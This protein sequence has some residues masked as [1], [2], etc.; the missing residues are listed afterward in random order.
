MRGVTLHNKWIGWI[1]FS[2]FLFHSPICPAQ[3]WKTHFAYNNVTQI[4]MSPD[5]VY[6][7]SDGSLYS[8][9]KQTEQ[10]QVYNSQS[11]LHSTGISCI[12]YDATGK[13]LI[14]A[15]FTGKIDILSSYGVKYISELYDKDMTQCK[16][17]YNVTIK[18]RTAYL[19]THYGVQTMDLRENK[20]VDSYW[21]RPGGQETPVKDVL[22][23]NDSIYAFT[24]DSLFCASMKSN[25]VDYTVWKRE[26]RSGRVAPDAEKGVHYQDATDHWYAGY[27][28]GIVRFTPTGRETYKPQGPINNTPYYVSAVGQQVF[29]L[30]GGRWTEQDNRPGNIMR[31]R[32]REWHTITAEAIYAKTQLLALDMMNVAV[33]PKDA[34]HYFVTSYGTGL[35]EFRGDSCV[36]HTL[37]NG[38]IGSAAPAYPER[39]TRLLGA[40]FDKKNR[41]WFL[42]AGAVDYPIILKDG[43]SFYGVPLTAEDQPVTI[44]IP[45]D[46]LIDS[47]NENY[48][49]TG[50]AYKGTGLVL[51]D[52]HG[53][54]ADPSD[55]KT[56]YRSSWV[57]Q[58]GHT[59]K[60]ENLHAIV[61]DR[62]GR[63]WMA[64]EQG[65]AYI[66]AETDF[67][68]SDAVVQPDVTDNNGE[69]PI[70]SLVA[71]A[72]CQTPDGH[73][74]IGTHTL[75]VYVLNEEATEITAHYTTDNSSM[76]ANG[77][78]SLTCSDEGHIFIGTSEGLVEYDPN[79]PDEG[80][81]GQE[82]G[83]LTW[84][85][86]SMQRWKLHLSYSNPQQVAA[87]PKHVFAAANGSLFSVDRADEA[88]VRWNK[89]TGL[90]GN[91]VSHIAY[92]ADAGKLIIAYENGQID[93]LDD[94]GDVTQMPDISMKAGSI[95][96]AI[97]HICVGSSQTYLA[98]PFGIIA[99]STR[100]GE[101]S[102]TYYI[103]TE[104]A[105]VEVQ[106]IVEEGD[107]LYA[108]SYDRLYKA[109]L[110]DN[111]VDY[112]F[113]QSEDLPFEK[114]DQAAVYNHHIYALHNDSLLRREN[115][116][117]H[118]VVPNKLEWIHVSG[119][120]LLAFERNNGLLRLTDDDQLTGL[121]GAF[122]ATDAVYSN[123]EYW[124]AEEGQG[125]VRL[126]GGGSDVFRPEGPMNN[127]GYK[128]QVAH[129]RLYVAPGGR[130][131]EQ[132][133]RQS[134]LSIY[135]GTQWQGI[136]W[137]DIFVKSGYHDMRDAVGYAVDPGDPDHFYVATYGTGVF[138]FN[139][140]AVTHYDGTDPLCT[141]RPANEL[142]TDA[143]FTRTDGA[144]LDEQGN[145]WVLNATTIG[146]PVHVMTPAGQ[147]VGLRLR[148]EGT[149]LQFETPSGIWVDLRNSQYKWMMGQRGEARLVLLD[150]GGTPTFNGDDR[151]ISRSA[152][153]DQNG[154]NLSPVI[155]RCFAQ[156]LTNR[157]W[158]GTDKGLITIPSNVDFFTSNSCR[159]III[160]RN[161]GTGLGDYLLGDE[162][163]NCMAVDGG[164]RMWIGTANSGLYLI[165]DDTIT[166]AHFTENNSLL[167]SN[168]V[169]SIAIIPSTGEVFVGTDRGIASY[170][171]DASEPQNDMNGA[172]AYPNPVRPDYNGVISITG[173]MD[174]T[175]VNII[176][177]G[178][179]LVCKT[180]SHGGTAV[181]DG[182]L[183]DGRR[184]TAGVY[185]ALCNAI[186]GHAAVK[187]L[188]IR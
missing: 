48:K 70:T 49:W 8:V 73:I 38:V 75:G 25:L 113:W 29:M 88:L 77:I 162:Q 66:D 112:S 62:K 101:V 99:I 139:H 141:L 146:R 111:L 107:S 87:T 183:P 115:N 4:A 138:E 2:S 30:S 184:A 150:D 1:V 100:K 46:L 56:C 172:Y 122:V 133:G 176:D 163:V 19:S 60:P 18:G 181:W 69:N 68:T 165:E 11:G 178:G 153:V 167:P 166:V 127:F 142:V 93:L 13:Q 170:R 44:E 78:L 96:V 80:L 114:A 126:S 152:F 58:H 95:A 187:I 143:Y 91:S 20:L 6:A 105:S 84:D 117:W 86:G 14:I 50:I 125:L 102:D 182:R 24:D 103:G 97:N 12:H 98:M 76:P 129:D 106:Q 168:S 45:C 36:R 174:N 90:N 15:Y 27:A 34:N 144:M 65:A 158:V 89:A 140:D 92:D 61:Q 147:W 118:L 53:T 110:K 154:N 42:N 116:G 63:T 5:K 164:N 32:D 156:D 134:S 55:D 21:L 52:D 177:S 10:I 109:S 41:L 179:N 121:S 17:I 160:P 85:E 59:F 145:L 35:Y 148:H 171:S 7:L 159:R 72:I 120:Q 23:A 161:D 188:V 155:L 51:L 74:W 67:F 28:E 157:I 175:V 151:C 186:K 119:N 64:T 47:R 43:N 71:R 136:P 3:K 22:L 123:G 128:L 132:F 82:E 33:D 81:S 26:I 108:F 16:T 79:G 135:D 169:Q 130:W 54:P 94:N 131:A 104:A 185:T 57:N 40:H 31:Y 39:Y 149:D 124:L 173:L 137:F 180:R 9:D 37:A 83:D